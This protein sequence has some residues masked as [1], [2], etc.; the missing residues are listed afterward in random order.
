MTRL[1]LDQL[2][3]HS[4]PSPGPASPLEHGN[5]PTIPSHQVSRIN[6]FRFD[7][8]TATKSL[9]WP[10][11]EPNTSLLLRGVWPWASSLTSLCLRT[12]SVK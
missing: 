2:W 7:L 6:E 4:L 11:L 12:Q 1:F 3:G 9:N 5:G 8:D 10:D